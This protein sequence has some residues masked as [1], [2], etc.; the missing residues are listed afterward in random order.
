MLHVAHDA[1]HDHHHRTAD[2]DVV[3]LAEM[4]PVTLLAGME[5][6]LAFRAGKHA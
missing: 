2:I 5:V 1:Q 6:W 3:V 4:I